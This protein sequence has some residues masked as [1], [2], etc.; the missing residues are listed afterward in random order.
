MFDRTAP[1]PGAA[2]KGSAISQ[3]LSLLGTAGGIGVS[4]LVTPLLFVSVTPRPS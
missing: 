2:A 1:L 4:I 3:G